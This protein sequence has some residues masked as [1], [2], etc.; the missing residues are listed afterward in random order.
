MLDTV[1]DLV[2]FEALDSPSNKGVDVWPLSSHQALRPLHLE[3]VLH[4]AEYQ[5]DRVE[6][7]LVWD[8]IDGSDA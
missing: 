8:I 5:L 1:L 2:C 3:T 7:A 4:L 6:L